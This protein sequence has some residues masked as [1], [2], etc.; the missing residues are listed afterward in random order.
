MRE[1]V[2]KRHSGKT[3]SKKELCQRY[4]QLSLPYD[5]DKTDTIPTD[6]YIP[7]LWNRIINNLTD[8]S[9]WLVILNNCKNKI[10]FRSGNYAEVLVYF[11]QYCE[12]VKN[13]GL[14]EV[15]SLEAELFG[16]ADNI[17]LYEFYYHAKRACYLLYSKTDTSKPFFYQIHYFAKYNSKLKRLEFFNMALKRIRVGT[18]TN[19]NDK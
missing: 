1:I 11:M 19:L 3:I 12:T 8:I 7:V 14:K 13:K 18:E 4:P 5:A 2:N 17:V 10:L 15:I 16:L 9:Q 6:T